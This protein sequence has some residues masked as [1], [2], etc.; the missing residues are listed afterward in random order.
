VGDRVHLIGGWSPRRLTL[1]TLSPCLSQRQ[2]AYI[3][4]VHQSHIDEHCAVID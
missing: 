4:G 2:K 1:V 3:I